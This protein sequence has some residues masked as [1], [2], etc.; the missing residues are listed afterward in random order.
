[1][2]S[3][4]SHVVSHVVSHGLRALK[5]S[6]AFTLTAV[7]T[8]GLGI[9]A[10]AAIYSVANAVIWRALPYPDPARLVIAQ[11]DDLKRGV[12]D[13]PIS[14]PDFLDLRNGSHDVF[15]SLDAIEAQS[16]HFVLLGADGTPE[17]I[18][19]NAV[20]TGFLRS[21]GARI[22]V[23]RNFEDAD[24]IEQTS[25][26]STQSA[27]LSYEYWRRRYGGDRSIVGKSILGG[28]VVVVG[29]LSPGFELLLPPRLNLERSP[30]FWFAER[31]RYD[32]AGRLSAHLYLLGRLKPGVTLVRAQSSADLVTRQLR[33]EFVMKE[34]SGYLFRVVPMQQHLVAEVRPAL[35]ALMGAVIF[36]LLIAC[37][38]VANLQLVRASRQGREWAVRTALGAR[39]WH[40]VRQTLAESLLVAS[41]G[42]MLGISLAWIALRELLAIAPAN[43]PRLDQVRIDWSVLAFT[44]FA[45]LL[46]A[47]LI[48][49]A[50]ILRASRPDVIAVL[51]LS[52]RGGSFAGGG[53]LRNTVAIAEVAL[54]FMLLTGSGLMLRSFLALRHTDPGFDP[55]H[56]LTIELAGGPLLGTSAQHAVF[57]RELQNR[58]R[59]LPGVRSV[60][61][62]RVLPLNGP[63]FPIRWGN[64]SDNVDPNALTTAADY[65]VALP[66]YFE[67]L[68][69]RLL[70]GRL[71]TE[72]DNQPGRTVLIIDDLLARKAF[73]GS[74][75]A[76]RRLL[77]S[78][79]GTPGATTMEVIGVVAHQRQSSLAEEG[80]EEL[81]FPNAY[82]GNWLLDQWAVRVD[83]DP[84]KIAGPTRAEVSKMGANLMVANMRPMDEILARAQAAPRFALILLVVFAAISAVLAGVGLYGV[85]STSVRQR[86]AEIGVRM[87]LGASPTGIVAL[88]A[89]QA[90]RLSVA[91]IAL[92]LLAAFGL[93]RVIGNSIVGIQ[94]ADP[95]TFASMAAVFLAIAG[96]ASWLPAQ[97]AARLDPS[98]ALRD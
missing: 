68:G 38:N 14:T 49:M 58:L 78:N 92:G 89:G 18:H 6:Q 73:P 48:G 13:F 91:G 46:T 64:L 85:L 53:L 84:S 50:P 4:L 26:P 29:V 65:Q 63:F 23:G 7:L 74:R 41:L 32:N 79:F 75:A 90:L 93:S 83:G 33:R 28:A 20:T 10:S 95:L 11:R 8:I 3:G 12:Q 5:N 35:L 21:L 86:T 98:T 24:G 71:F 15:Q 27:I 39:S 60:A 25:G 76:G 56:L 70:E 87:A 67:A 82:V 1:M 66:G 51:R 47:A 30:D 72:D 16:A 62:A 54:C 31:P 2:P 88:V 59:A 43:L 37:S 36:L 55:H 77:V 45:T 57:L 19:S 44:A 34:A 9:G 52:G 40:L 96:L 97:R 94:A 42:A 22:E 81:F 80:H 69:A 61:G 17:H